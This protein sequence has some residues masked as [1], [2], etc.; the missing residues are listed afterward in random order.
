VMEPTFD[1]ALAKL[2]AAQPSNGMRALTLPQP[3]LP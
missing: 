2:V 1:E 3:L